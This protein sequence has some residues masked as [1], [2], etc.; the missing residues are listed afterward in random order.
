[1]APQEV[2]SDARVLGTQ[3]GTNAHRL[4]RR[5]KRR[6]MA[7]TMRRARALAKV[8][9]LLTNE[10]LPAGCRRPAGGTPFSPGQPPHPGGGVPPGALA[11]PQVACPAAHGPLTDPTAA[12]LHRIDR[13]GR[14]RHL[15]T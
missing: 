3:E 8:R 6:G 12:T 4:A 7:W 15:R 13:G 14:M 1:V 9:E 5:R 10:T 11:C 2:P